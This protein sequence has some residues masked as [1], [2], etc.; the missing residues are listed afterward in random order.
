EPPE[1]DEALPEGAL[2]TP[3]LADLGEEER[4]LTTLIE[5]A[6]RAAGADSKERRLLRLLSRASGE[7]VIVFTEYR[8]TLRQLAAV[9][10]DA[11]H[12]HGGLT[13]AE[14]AVVQRQFNEH[15]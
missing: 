6:G 13:S 1:P 5:A 8:D 2:A 3:G 7:A 9:L 11:L 15:G 12:L 4:W 10:P 14:R